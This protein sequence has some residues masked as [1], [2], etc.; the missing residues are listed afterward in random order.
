MD[1]TRRRHA[2]LEWRKAEKWRVTSIVSLSWPRCRRQLAVIGQRLAR[3]AARML[4]TKRDRYTI[5]RQRTQRSSDPTRG[6]C[7]GV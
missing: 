3:M 7:H 5:L 1:T 4:A 2:S 6:V